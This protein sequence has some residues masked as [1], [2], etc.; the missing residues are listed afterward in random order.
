MREKGFAPILILVGI[1]VIL[2]IIGGV[3]Y[4]SINRTSKPAQT[5]DSIVNQSISQPTPKPS[6]GSQKIILLSNAWNLGTKTYSNPKT[7]ITFEYP[8][9]FEAKET[10]VQKANQEWAE[11]YKNDPNVKPLHESTFLA[12]FFT[13]EIEVKNEGNDTEY[14]RKWD[15]FCDNKMLVSVQEYDNPQNLSLYDFIANSHKSYPGGGKTETFDTYKKD[16]ETSNLPKEGS[17]VF[18]GIVA[19]NPVKTVYFST[20]GKVYTFGLIGNCNTGGQYTSDANKVF[21]NILKSIRY[22]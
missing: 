21:E 4:L 22:Q 16:L 15:E 6:I 10:D 5:Q 9:Y 12:S 11:K 1:I 14:N 8:L 18:E 19:E 17:Y 2:G 20:K 3:Y 13:P 7:S